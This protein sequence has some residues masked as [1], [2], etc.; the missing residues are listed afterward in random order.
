VIKVTKKNIIVTSALPY[1]N[2]E[3]HIGHIAST[4]LPADIF[5]RYCRLKKL[6]VIYIC[7]GDDY[8]TP[9]LLK[10]EEEKKTP[11]D[12]VESWHQQHKKDFNDLGI[13]F[14][15][16]YQTHS[17][18]NID[19]VQ[20]FFSILN[21]KRYIYTNEIEQFY[22]EKDNKFL[23]DRYIKG[24]CPSCK[25]EDQYGDSCEKCGKTYL[26]TEIIKP[27]CAICGG[28]PVIKKTV[29]YFF[30]LSSLSS[31]LKD[32]L[33]SNENL[34]DEVKNYVLQW[35]KGGLRDWDITR[36]ISWGVK[37]PLKEAENKTLYGWFDNHLGYISFTL[38]YLND[39]GIDGKDFWNNSE[40]YHFIGK[41]IVYH[42]YLFLPAMR[43]AEG[44]FRL[45]DFIPTR[46][47]LLLENRKLSKSRGWYISI[48]EFLSKHPSDY[49]RYYLSIITSYSQS[50][51]NF[52]WRDFEKR[53]N[54]ELVANIGNFVHRTLTFLSTNF[55]STLPEPGEYDNLDREMEDYI[56]S[57]S[58]DVGKDMDKNHLDRALKIIMDFSA[59]C[60]Q[61]FQKKEPWKTKDKNC[62]YLSVN[63]VRSLAIL[64]EPFMPSSCENIWKQLNLEGSVHEQNWNS[65]SEILIKT[66]HRINK[67]EI[68]FKKIL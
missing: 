4:Y 67:P 21:E 13:S 63:A 25:A 43:I 47:Y 31:K 29:H 65:A 32:W 26:S 11:E 22:C 17:K 10:A 62:L 1:S 30:K 64:L 8:G 52:D 39:K 61:Y 53:I 54:N 51:I 28:V 20:N 60:N 50:D 44:T 58:T 41:D 3:I 23:P 5:V 16:Y 7:G 40:I 35:I 68:L 56:K 45:P 27:K 38:K 24:T 36:D 49:L 14:D 48:K 15:F 33:E 2:G 19:L 6:D 46:G 34:Q 18:E 37:I 42:H 9:I 59:F 12:Y 66:G 57:I 55:E